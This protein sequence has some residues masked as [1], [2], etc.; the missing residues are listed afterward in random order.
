[1]IGVID[2]RFDSIRLT[3]IGNDW[4]WGIGTGGLGLGLGLG[5]G[6]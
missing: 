6:D 1:M 4:D 5:L 3:T 2:W